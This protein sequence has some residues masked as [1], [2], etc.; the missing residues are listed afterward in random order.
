MY[1]NTELYVVVGQFGTVMSV[2]DSMQTAK[3]TKATLDAEKYGPHYVK[4]VIEAAQSLIHASLPQNL[5]SAY[6]Q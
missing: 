6:R 1:A 2:P 5:L 3:D 4:P